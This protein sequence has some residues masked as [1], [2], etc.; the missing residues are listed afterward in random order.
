MGSLFK[1]TQQKTTS[2]STPWGPQGDQLKNVFGD[3]QGIYDS[4]KGTPYYSGELYA[5]MDPLTSQ[6]INANAGYATGAGADA[7][8]NVLSSGQNLLGAG[9][10]GLSAYNSL[11]GAATTDPTQGNIAS[12]GAYADNPYLSGQIDAAS[13]DITRNLYE[14]QIPGLNMSATGSGNMNSSRAGVAQGIMTRGA[15][16]QIGDIASQMRG[17]AYSQGLN[18]AEQGRESNMGYMGQA[19]QGYGNVYGQGLGASQQGQNM[20]YQNNDALIQG[21]QLNQQDQQ[22][23]D[24]A[25]YQQWQGQDQRASDLL[26]RYYGIVGGQNWGGTATGSQPGQ[27]MFQTLLGAAA[28]GAGAYFGA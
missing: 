24:N 10:Q 23:Q 11:M 16:D 26:N 14:N 3:A 13:R 21:G 5:G 9:Q 18:L 4:Q 25:G 6:G 17:N 2:T 1:P 7:A 8:S 22:G 20:T 28:A 15:A 12:A 27:S 19:A